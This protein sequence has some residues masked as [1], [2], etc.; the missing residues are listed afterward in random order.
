MCERT[1]REANE[2]FFND[3]KALRDS[4]AE[5]PEVYHAYNLALSLFIKSHERWDLTEQLSKKD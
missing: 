1:P 3:I 2:I 4:N 5:N